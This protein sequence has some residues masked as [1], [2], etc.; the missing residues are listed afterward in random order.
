LRYCLPTT[1]REHGRHHHPRHSGH[2]VGYR[3]DYL[4]RPRARRRVHR[5]RSR[6]GRTCR[7]PRRRPHTR[8]EALESIRQGVRRNFGA[9]AQGIARGSRCATTMARIRVGS[10]PEGTHVPR[11]R[12]LTAFVRAPEGYGAADRDHR[13]TRDWG[14]G[15]ASAFA[16]NAIAG[17]MDL[18]VPWSVT[19]I[20]VDL[21]V[22]RRR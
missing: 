18:L 21:R 16:S 11:H 8:F 3:S 6:L 22:V 20:C 2:D 17:T 15:H 4:D 7:P 5:R 10:F 9:F 19:M 1:V 14:W 13:Q 12:K